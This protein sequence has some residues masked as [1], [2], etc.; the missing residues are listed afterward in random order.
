M[1]TERAW[2]ST[3]GPS[4]VAV[5][6]GMAAL[7]LGLACGSSTNTPLFDD[8]DG[9]AQGGSAGA[10]GLDAA[11][12]AIDSASL[13]D[14]AG[15][16]ATPSSCRG[17]AECQP[18]GLVCDPLARRCAECLFDA[19]CG[20][21]AR[22]VDRKCRAVVSCN[23]SLDCA[24]APDPDKVCDATTGSCVEC[25]S[26]DDCSSAHECIANR[27]VGYAPCANSL[28]CPSGRVCDTDAKR[29]VDCVGNA[30]CAKGQTCANSRCAKACA[31]DIVCTG[32]GLLCDKTAGHCVE[33]LAHADCPGPYHCSAG[34]CEL[35]VCMAGTSN[36]KGN[37]V[38]RCNAAGDG[39]DST[40]CGARQTC[41]A[42]GGVAACATWICTAGMAECD[43]SAKKLITC[44]ADGLSVATTVDCSAQGQVCFA[45]K[46][47]TLIC[48]P[49]MRFCEGKALKQCSADGLSATTVQTCLTT[50]YCDDAS[51]T[52]R[53][54]VCTPN[55]PGCDGTRAA[56]CNAL[57]SGW[58]AGTDCNTLVG[59]RCSA[60]ACVCAAS[61]ADCDG[62]PTTGC[63]ENLSTSTAHC[64]ACKAACSSN[65]I[66]SLVC[67][68]GNCTGDCNVGFADCDL[69]KRTNGCEIDLTNDAAHCG[70]CTTPCSSA[71]MQSVTC[72]ANVCNGM[73][74]PGFA[75]CDGNKQTNGCERD[76][77]NDPDACGGCGLSCSSTGMATRTCTA[78][79]CNGMC[80]SG[81]ADCD[82]NKLSNGC[83]IN[84]QTDPA[85]CGTCGKQCATP[86]LPS[87]VVTTQCKTSSC[88]VA[89]CTAGFAD[90]NGSF[91]DGCEID[92]TNDQANCGSCGHACGQGC[93]NS[94]CTGEHV[95][96]A[97]APGTAAY[98]TDVQAKIQ[99][100]GQFVTVDIIN[101][102]TTT[103]SL[104][105]LQAYEA[106]LV[107]SNSPSFSD[108]TTFGNNLANYWDGGGRVVV[109]TF[110]N[111]STLAIGGRWVSD[112]YP[113]IATA[114]QTQPAET[115]PLQLVEPASPLLA[116]V[117]SLT[118]T[119]AFRS[120]GG[121]VNG[122][123]I[124]AKWGSGAPLIVRGTRN[125]RNRVDLNMFPPSSAASPPFWVGSGAAI[126]SNALL[127]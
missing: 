8:Q 108:A 25:R 102:G 97:A 52:C 121:V 113:L 1:T 104:A 47:Q 114:A 94:K 14:S 112:G 62:N 99:S 10:P 23:N 67:S 57:G 42:P 126:L 103:P 3:V 111:T 79:T 60:G 48:A 16:A 34:S 33:C 11:F 41:S 39:Y 84:T 77:T 20:P 9:A 106:V 122:G 58:L 65:H 28:D 72:A 119:S 118:A 55:Q 76:L 124:V 91:T 29:C 27:C 45:G 4:R 50:E 53:T 125:G 95:L 83:E 31:S 96:V 26:N 78:S 120:S 18:A 24:K 35:D 7:V 61:R 2:K 12:D 109:A 51:T 89:T 71:N 93:V 30:D 105:T 13:R 56:V 32:D 92:T 44:A 115:L 123:V 68:A 6:W 63:E 82:G 88:A 64:G 38:R 127:Y 110:A 66:A 19:S 101:A 37:A 40:P 75:D 90:C 49:S 116:G 98:L 87:N 22:C 117:V 17:D 70:S 54:G 36:C 100:T 5:L 43:A 73:C 69:D 86:P 15:E 85:N 21:N 107:F 80:T 81:F 46:C 74:S 59:E